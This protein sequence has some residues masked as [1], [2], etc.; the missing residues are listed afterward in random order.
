M[1]RVNGQGVCGCVGGWGGG[2]FPVGGGGFLG[3]LPRRPLAEFYLYALPTHHH[4]LHAM[5]RSPPLHP[6]AFSLCVCS[7]GVGQAPKLSSP[8]SRT[9]SPRST[10]STCACRAYRTPPSSCRLVGRLAAGGGSGGV[11]MPARLCLAASAP[12]PRLIVAW[13]GTSPAAAAEAHLGHPPALLR[14][15]RLCC[16]ARRTHHSSQVDFQR[17]A[18]ITPENEYEILQLMMG[19]LRDRCVRWWWWWACG[20]RGVGCLVGSV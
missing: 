3:R 16:F 1:E 20:V 10:S 8:F 11:G 15:P 9:A 7:V 13:R 6:T 17:D 5:P 18:V 2:G 14:H 12:P 19:D 4:Y